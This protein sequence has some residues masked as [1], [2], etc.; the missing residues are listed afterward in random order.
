MLVL[1]SGLEESRHRPVHTAQLQVGE[2]FSG[3]ALSIVDLKDRKVQIH[4]FVF[5]YSFK[6]LHH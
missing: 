2:I 1:W 4:D 3:K 6:L 5:K